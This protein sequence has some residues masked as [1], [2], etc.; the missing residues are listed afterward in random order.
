MML[1]TTRRPCCIVLLSLTFLLLAGFATHVRAQVSL[2]AS[3]AAAN[4]QFGYSV[5]LSGTLGLVGAVRKN[6]S[7]D[8]AYLF[9]G[10]DTATGTVP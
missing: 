7:Q 8:A 10:R 5:S 1:N 4:D 6:S 2:T 9:R 3:D